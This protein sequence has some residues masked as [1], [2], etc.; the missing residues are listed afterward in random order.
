MGTD[1]PMAR[2][3]RN[4]AVVLASVQ[5]SAEELAAMLDVGSSQLNKR[6]R[7]SIVMLVRRARNT[8][9][10]TSVRR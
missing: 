6:G 2:A 10:C 7:D 9:N 5:S 4:V 1:L 8:L 3:A